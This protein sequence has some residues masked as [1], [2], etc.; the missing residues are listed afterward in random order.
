M[1]IFSIV[2]VNK[3]NLWINVILEMISLFI[4]FVKIFKQV[5]VYRDSRHINQMNIFVFKHHG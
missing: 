4:H 1:E 2:S 5:N 3:L